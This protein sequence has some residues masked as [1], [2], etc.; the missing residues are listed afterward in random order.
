[1]LNYTERSPIGVAG[2][3]SP[4]NLPLYL[5]SFKIAPAL[6]SGNTVVCKPSEMTSYT[7]WMLCQAFH[8]IG[9]PK[10]VLNLVCGYGKLFD[11]L[12]HLRLNSILFV[13]IIRGR[14]FISQNN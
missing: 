9:L 1:M 4:W 10:G 2:L 3:I 14:T 11:I 7:A 12:C 8:D 5:L 6:M 13:C